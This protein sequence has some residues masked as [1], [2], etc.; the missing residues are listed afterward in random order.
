[1][2]TRPL[3]QIGQELIPG[4]RVRQLRGRGSFGSVW[5][6]EAADGTAYAF[7]VMPCSDSTAAA[8]EIRA[9][10]A[11]R[12]LC[13]PHIIRIEQVWSHAG[14]FIVG[15]ELADG[16]LLDLLEAYQSEYGTALGAAEACA[17]LTQ[18]AAAL[19]YLNARQHTRDGRRVGFQHGDIKPSNL[20]LFGD[21]LKVGDLGLL[22]P[23]SAPV[24]FAHWAGTMDYAA[25]EVFQGRLTDWSDQYAL[26]VSY[27]QVRSGRLP[28]PAMTSSG[29]WPRGFLR[30]P[31][32]LSLLSEAERPVLRR[33]LALVPQHRWPSC[34]EL[35]AQLKRAVAAEQG[36]RRR[37]APR[38]F[39]PASSRPS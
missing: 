25:P 12:D 7:K 19:D 2:N 31:P 38:T 11:V 6:V 30:P 33:A 14:S 36:P 26:A 24:T 10:Q 21:T 3:A 4:Y 39:Q 32:D 34:G 27:C 23:V 8:K 16:S 35:M 9:L 28:F 29:S 17:Y 37:H 15:M 13:H 5:E 18:A 22:R 20:L 1:V